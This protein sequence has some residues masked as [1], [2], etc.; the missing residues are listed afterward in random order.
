[1]VYT[2][3]SSSAAMPTSERERPAAVTAGSGRSRSPGFV[4]LFAAVWLLLYAAYTMLPF[5]RPGSVVIA[6]AKFDTLVK[7]RMF[8]PH[9]RYR[10]MVFGHSKALTSVR[11]RELD[12]RWGREF[13]SYNLGLPGE[14]AISSDPGSCVGGRQHSHSRAVDAAL[15][16]KA[17]Q[18][19]LHG[20]PARRYRHRQDPVAVPHVSARCDPVPVRE[21]KPASGR[22][23]RRCSP[24]RRHARSSAA[25]TSSSRRVTTKGSPAGRLCAADRSSGR[26]YRQG[27]SRK[28]LSPARVS[29]S[30]QRNTAFKSSSF[31]CRFGSASSRRPRPRTMP[32][33]D[34]LRTIRAFVFWDRIISAIRPHFS[35]IPSTS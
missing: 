31:R 34:H 7:G 5:T 30:S 8:G 14:E 4:L 6:D 22:D 23:P 35:R 20:F 32:D 1:M 18:A 26:R 16:R 9:D 24:A 19:G 33:W 28:R 25:G 11:P 13:R 17:R 12:R 21:Q 10:V 3:P 2:S 15:G 27:S 29:S